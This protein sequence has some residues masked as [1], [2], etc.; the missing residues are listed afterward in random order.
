MAGAFATADALFALACSEG[1]SGVMKSH[2]MGMKNG[3]W[4][5]LERLLLGV[6]LATG[7]EDG[8]CGAQSQ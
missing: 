7:L 8:V 1:R 2:K 4:V 6:L 5:G 3:V